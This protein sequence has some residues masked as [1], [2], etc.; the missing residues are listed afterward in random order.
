MADAAM[1][2]GE[3]RDKVD[4]D[5]DGG[6]QHGSEEGLDGRRNRGMPEKHSNSGEG[7]A[8]DG[9]SSDWTE[10]HRNYRNGEGGGPGPSGYDDNDAH[11]GGSGGGEEVG[12]QKDNT[13]AAGADSEE[14]GPPSAEDLSYKHQRYDAGWSLLQKAME[15]SSVAGNIHVVNGVTSNGSNGGNNGV[16]EPLLTECANALSESYLSNR[17]LFDAAEECERCIRIAAD[18]LG[19]VVEAACPKRIRRRR[20]RVGKRGARSSVTMMMQSPPSPSTTA[21]SSPLRTSTAICEGMDEDGLLV[22]AALLEGAVA[23]APAAVVSLDE[24]KERA[25]RILDEHRRA[26]VAKHALLM[27]PKR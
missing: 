17:D 23:T 6:A 18:G 11:N 27:F 8:G 19:E 9:G 14:E 25:A 15:A 21:T 7:F 24:L 26:V 4:E 20:G 16:D 13:I 1:M 22:S 12:K 10:H 5:D 2:D 3:E